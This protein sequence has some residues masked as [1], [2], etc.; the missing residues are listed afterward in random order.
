MIV[1]E[2]EAKSIVCRNSGSTGD[3]LCLATG[4]MNWRWS[5]F[6][7]RNYDG[8]ITVDQPQKGYC[9]LAGEPKVFS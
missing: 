6:L 8:S 1:T 5:P 3:R 9:G 7:E 2:E 4:C